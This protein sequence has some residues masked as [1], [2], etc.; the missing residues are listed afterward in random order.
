MVSIFA[1]FESFYSNWKLSVMILCIVG[2]VNVFSM[3]VI[4][5]VRL[6]IKIKEKL[7]KQ[8]NVKL[9]INK[10]NIIE[11]KLEQIQA[12]NVV[13]VEL[14]FVI[15][16]IIA[17]FYFKYFKDN[18]RMFGMIIFFIGTNICFIRSYVYYIKI[19]KNR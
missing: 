11:K 3:F 16:S 15:F 13:I 6:K 17:F 18:Y 5:C 1:Y 9:E 14:C 19:R 12:L 4:N 10:N 2:I 7:R 8:E